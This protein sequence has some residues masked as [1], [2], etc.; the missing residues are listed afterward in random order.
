[1]WFTFSAASEN[2]YHSLV[3]FIFHL[4]LKGIE[5]HT[6]EMSREYTAECLSGCC[7]SG[8]AA[9]AGVTD[10]SQETHL[11]II[12]NPHGSWEV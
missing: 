5:G 2:L 8:G 6:L 3:I 10:R 12:P 9:P 7:V 1:M 4:G 11:L